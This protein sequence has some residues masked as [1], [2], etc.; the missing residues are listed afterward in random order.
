LYAVQ[1]MLHEKHDS[2]A[3]SAELPFLDKK[4]L[5]IVGAECSCRYALI[6]RRERRTANE[7]RTGRCVKFSRCV[8]RY[9][10]P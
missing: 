5:E 3:S 2:F 7:L 9:R 1:N 4:R 10:R 6:P 8:A